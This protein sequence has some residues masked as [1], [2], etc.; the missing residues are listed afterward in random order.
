ME[1]FKARPG[2]IPVA[3]AVTVKLDADARPEDGKQGG[4][5]QAAPEARLVVYGDSDFANN[6]FFN[7]LG[8]RD[9]FLNTVHWL[10]EEEEFIATRPPKEGD[11]PSVLSPPPDRPPESPDLLD[12]WNLQPA[13]VLLVGII[14]SW[15]KKRRG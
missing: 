8:N 7:V 10:A 2:P 14:V 13:F 15:R 11:R 1:D 9:F 12:R 3:A 6:Y 5:D 4:L